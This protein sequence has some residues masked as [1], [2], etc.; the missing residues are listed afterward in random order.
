[1]SEQQSLPSTSS[2]YQ[3]STVANEITTSPQLLYNSEDESRTSLIQTQKEGSNLTYTNLYCFSGKQKE[4]P[5]QYYTP[6][7]GNCIDLNNFKKL[8]T[9]G[10][11][12]YGPVF[13]VQN[14]RSKIIK[15]I[16]K[17]IIGDLRSG[18]SNCSLRELQILQSCKHP[19]VL[20]LEDIAVSKGMEEC[21]LIMEY[22]KFDLGVIMYFEDNKEPFTLAEVKSII[23]QILQGINYLHQRKI[24]H[25]DLKPDNI[26]ITAE[27]VV[28]IADFGLA[29]VNKSDNHIPLTPDMVTLWYRSPEIL[30]KMDYY[31]TK[32]DI[33]SLGCIFAELLQHNPLFTGNTELNQY[34][35][36]CELLG[37]PNTEIWPGFTN[38]TKL[39]TFPDTDKSYCYLGDIF[40]FE[41]ANTQD[42]LYCMLTMNPEWRSDAVQCLNHEY[43]S[44][45]PEPCEPSELINSNVIKKFMVGN[46]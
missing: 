45:A 14:K 9:I 38:L 31:T 30:L 1:M 33:W 40:E 6:I 42:L 5:L 37:T 27:G 24:I 16:K 46:K 35:Q 17:V 34:L 2:I 44:E 23:K 15:A 4:A 43:F 28:K 20:D 18:I 11:G 29:K 3:Q 21:Y 32:S 8:T 12:A 39:A 22:C 19:N 13:K 25:R 36:I 26:L 7:L 41:T 10:E